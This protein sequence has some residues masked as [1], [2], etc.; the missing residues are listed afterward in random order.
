[1]VEISV[2]TLF[3]VSLIFCIGFDISILVA[4][5]FGFFLFF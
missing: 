4:L 2:L 1:M 5:V 3:A